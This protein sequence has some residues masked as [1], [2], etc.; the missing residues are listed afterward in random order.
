MKIKDTIFYKI[1][2]PLLFFL[3]YL[4]YRPTII[5][6]E[7]IEKEGPIVLAGNHTKWLDPIMLVAIVKRQVHFLAKIELFKGPISLITKGMGA[8]P[9]NRKIHDKNALETAITSLKE[10]LCIGIFPEG[11]INRTNNLIMPFK[12]G[13]VKMSKETNATLIPFVITG[14][15]KLFRKSIKIEFLK[16]LKVSDDLEKSNQ[17][18][19]KLVEEKLRKD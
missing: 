3:V 19:M 15:Y 17:Q 10:G 18:L 5:G 8:I 1:V 2:K 7:N 12:I 16:P 6:K 11:T 14:K 9:V 13:A 4:L